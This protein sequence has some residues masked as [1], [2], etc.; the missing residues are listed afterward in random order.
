MEDQDG[1]R[2]DMCKTKDDGG[3]G[4]K[5]IGVFNIA[6]LGTWKWGLGLDMRGLGKEV[7]V[8]KYRS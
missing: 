4:I 8:S 5:D 3:L 7:M 6:L 2:G 1:S